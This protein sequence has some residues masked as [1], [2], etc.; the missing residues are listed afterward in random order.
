[1]S[2]EAAWLIERATSLTSA[3]EYLMIDAS[4]TGS[5]HS[6]KGQFAWT[7]S[8]QWALRFSRRHDAILFIGAMR[9]LSGSIPHAQTLRGLRLD[10]EA[11]RVCE[12]GW[13]PSAAPLATDGAKPEEAS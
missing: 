12:H 6:C 13:M 5:A 9:S 2:D 7:T 11:P 8:H 3:P 4:E 10:D 1:M